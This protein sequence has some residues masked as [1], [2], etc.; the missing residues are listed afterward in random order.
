M[1][2][3]QL[4]PP[5]AGELASTLAPTNEVVNANNGTN[6]ATSDPA[7]STRITPAP[8]GDGT[9]VEGAIVVNSSDSPLSE[10]SEEAVRYSQWDD[11]GMSYDGPFNLMDRAPTPCLS[12]AA[13]QDGSYQPRR[14]YHTTHEDWFDLAGARA[15]WGIEGLWG[16]RQDKARENILQELFP[17]LGEPYVDWDPTYGSALEVFMSKRQEAASDERPVHYPQGS[18]WPSSP[19]LGPPGQA[20]QQDPPPPEL[21]GV[22]RH[23]ERMRA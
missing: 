7:A 19:N 20:L 10:S 8:A 5:P 14:A 11:L 15:A 16:S 12:T 22:H 1:D 3:F 4:Q 6:I 9:L 2:P 23:H 21:G 18:L 13:L 17:D